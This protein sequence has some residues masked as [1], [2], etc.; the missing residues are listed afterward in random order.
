MA[1][2]TTTTTTNPDA[3]AEYT[4]R[5]AELE[6][7]NEAL[8]A[9]KPIGGQLTARVGPSGA[10]SLYGMGQFPVSL[11]GNQWTRLHEHLSSDASVG[12]WDL[13]RDSQ[14]GAVGAKGR[15]VG[16]AAHQHRIRDAEKRSAA[17]AAAKAARK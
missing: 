14:E 10:I 13:V 11:H 3:F 17:M 5:I 1:K 2:Q 8:K 16:N 6:A 7:E 9:A 15:P 4:A 12:L